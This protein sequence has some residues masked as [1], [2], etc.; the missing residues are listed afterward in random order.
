M[1]QE[2]ASQTL[3]TSSL[4]AILLNP[5]FRP[6]D[7][8]TPNPNGG[9]V[10]QCDTIVPMAPAKIRHGEILVISET[11]YDN[12]KHRWVLRFKGRDGRFPAGH[13]CICS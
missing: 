7:R 9:W 5:P 6:G 11:G 13:F 12:E 1:Q 3:E 2:V 4:T 8:V 10:P